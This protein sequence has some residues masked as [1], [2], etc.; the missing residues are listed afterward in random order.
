MSNNDEAEHIEIVEA[1]LTY[2]GNWTPTPC[3]ETFAV[4]NRKLPN[5][6]Q[7]QQAVIASSRDILA[8]CTPPIDDAG[9]RTVLVVG[10]VQS[11]KTLSFTTVAALA[12]DNGY[13]MVIVIAGTTTDLAEQSRD[14]LLDD[15]G[16]EESPFTR[17]QHFHNPSIGD[18]DSIRDVL[19]EWD[20]PNVLENERRTVL[21]TVLKN[22]TRLDNL[23]NV[24]AQLGTYVNAPV[25]IIDDEADQA[26]LNNL[27]SR[28]NLSTTYRRILELQNI[29]PH[30]SFLQYTATPQANLL[31]NLI[32]VL[33]PE[34]AVI[35]QPGSNYVGGSLVFAHGSPYVRLIP[36]H[37]I[38]TPDDHFG[39]PPE[40]LKEAMALFFIGVASG[41]HRRDGR[42]RNRSMMVHPSRLIAGHRQY[43]TWVRSIRNLWIEILQGNLGDEA[44]DALLNLFRDT[45]MNLTETIDDLE[46]FEQ[47]EPRLLSAV[48]STQL[49]E[50][51][52]RS[53]LREI[54]W[55]SNYSWILVGGTVLD[56][57]FT[58][59]GLT[60][61]YMPRGPGVGNADTI[62]QRARFLGYKGSY[63]GFCRVFLEQAVAHAYQVYVSHEED[64]RQRLI[65]HTATGNPLSAF[66]R[67]FICDRALRPTRQ[68]VLDIDYYR[69]TFRN[70][71]CSPK[72]L[73]ELNEHVESNRLLVSAFLNRDD[74]A[75]SRDDSGHP[76]RRDV[77]IHQVARAVSLELMY[78]EFLSNYQVGNIEDDQ[79]FVVALLLLDRYLSRNPEAT[80]TLYNMSQGRERRRQVREGRILNLFQGEY[81]VHPRERR[82]EIYPGD[83]QTIGE[84]DV[85]IQIHHVTFT[86]GPV[87]S[88]SIIFQDANILT[89]WMSQEVREDVLVQDQGGP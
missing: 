32:D 84:D 31:I 15:L 51:N 33:S 77:Q 30:Y 14:R 22:H 9:G 5:D 29:L 66:R 75:I 78:H 58:V 45:Q 65:D 69:Q 76:D 62:Q 19:A 8:Q 2:D 80:C 34:S 26:S 83:R 70:G 55:N 88:G 49:R 10:Y 11:G 73:P 39:E 56:R 28:E 16:L 41:L 35:L 37:E 42:P 7:G 18:T 82:G 27:V 48:R 21:V 12:N 85:T 54:R 6:Q 89:I 4:V 50:L 46:N 67:V 44:R 68:S 74:I 13:R 57:G 86:D 63:L 1:N 47:L 38:P 64:I 72:H 40:T 3:N 60:V 36:S 24:L 53:E 20:D 61:T 23:N 71:W 25:L 79:S 17:W 43:F 59:E 81:P 52:S 87:N